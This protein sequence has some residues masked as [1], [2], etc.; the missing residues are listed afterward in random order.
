MDIILSHIDGHGYVTN[1]IKRGRHFERHYAA[2]EVGARHYTTLP[3]KSGA[4]HTISHARKL[5]LNKLEKRTS[6]TMK[7]RE[8]GSTVAVTPPKWG[9]ATYGAG[10]RSRCRTRQRRARVRWRPTRVS[11]GTFTMEPDVPRDAAAPMN[12]ALLSGTK[13]SGASPA[14]GEYLTRRILAAMRI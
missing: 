7:G 1:P 10:R 13:Y 9:R 14:S 6:R 12:N 5:N 8:T 4:T 11:V 3:G 2:G